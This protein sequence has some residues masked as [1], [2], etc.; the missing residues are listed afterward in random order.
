[1]IT[2]FNRMIIVAAIVVSIVDTSSF[3]AIKKYGATAFI[4]STMVLG[5]VIPII[6]NM[7]Y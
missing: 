6:I 3:I 1:M 7:W 5:T 2:L 4:I